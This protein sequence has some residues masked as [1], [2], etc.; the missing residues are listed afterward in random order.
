M[1]VEFDLFPYL[2]LLPDFDN[3]VCNALFVCLP[4]QLLYC[5]LHNKN[6]NLKKFCHV[7]FR[8]PFEH[9][10]FSNFPSL[11]L[12]FNFLDSY[13]FL[14]DLL[15]FPHTH[16][17]NLH[18]SYIF[19]LFHCSHL[20]YAHLQKIIPWVVSTRL[21]PNIMQKQ[22]FFNKPCKNFNKIFNEKKEKEQ[23]KKS[24][25]YKQMSLKA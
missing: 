5:H 24:C 11:F 2:F 4:N 23:S 17:L 22:L 6:S 16:L 14:F 18:H 13:L 9:A 3:R 1:K 10:M 21:C 7:V 8:I 19:Q 20:S 25:I 15:D 12:H